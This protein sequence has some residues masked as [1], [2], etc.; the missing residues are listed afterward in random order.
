MFISF[1]CSRTCNKVDKS[2]LRVRPA[3]LRLSRRVLE[4]LAECRASCDGML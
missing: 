4:L 2:V 1:R 3:H